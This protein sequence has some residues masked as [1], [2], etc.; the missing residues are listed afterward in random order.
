MCKGRDPN[1]VPYELGYLGETD[2]KNVCRSLC[3]ARSGCTVFTYKKNDGCYGYTVYTGACV[4]EQGGYKTY[5][6]GKIDYRLYIG[7][8]APYNWFLFEGG[9]TDIT[10]P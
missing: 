8:T 5:N 4:L 9:A 10:N 1:R 2:D 6:A 7:P 3:L